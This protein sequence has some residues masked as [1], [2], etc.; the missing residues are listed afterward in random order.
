MIRLIT[1]LYNWP[2][3][4]YLGE[5][6]TLKKNLKIIL[7][8]LY[9][10]ESNKLYYKIHILKDKDRTILFIQRTIITL[11]LNTKIRIC[12]PGLYCQT[13]EIK[14]SCNKSSL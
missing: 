8:L 4:N 2:S 9:K 11:G 12:F 1:E 14:R 13:T 6:K 3:H 10:K 5:K 7:L